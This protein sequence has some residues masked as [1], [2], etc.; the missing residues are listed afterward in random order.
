[1]AQLVAGAIGG[2][3][4]AHA[5]TATLA[6]ARGLAGR[7]GGRL[8][9]VQPA[10]AKGLLRVTFDGY[11]S[12][13]NGWDRVRNPEPPPSSHAFAEAPIDAEVRAFLAPIPLEHA[14]VHRA[15]H[16]EGDVLAAAC[17]DLDGDGGMELV[18][19]SRTRV[20]AGHVNAGRFVPSRTAPWSALAPRSPV[21]MREPLAGA[22]I[23][24]DATPRLLVG[25]T[26]RGGVA[27]DASLVLVG[28]LRGIPVPAPDDACAT[29][30]PEA[31]AFEGDVTGCLP[32]PPAAVKGSSLP[33]RYDAVALA[34]LPRP[35]GSSRSAQ[36]A[37][38]P[39]GKLQVRWGE[40]ATTIDNVG[41]QVVVADLDQDGVP[42]LVTSAAD[43]EDAITVASWDGA[44]DPRVRLHLAAPGGVRA[45]CVCPPEEGSV[46]ALVAVV[47]SEVWIV[48]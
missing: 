37:R 7:G 39:A 32:T 4:R 38:E 41:A 43:G 1:V 17:G 8:V 29:P 15:K 16:D 45:L 27:L 22:S 30:F 2:A 25:T 6:Q 21:P 40:A 12:S 47:G 35:D 14:S 26:D 28:A 3:T 23:V 36:V 13:S 5:G 20:A 31:S 33:P 9:F 19:V 42:E 18:L 11:P 34:N 24:G 10:I 44:S 48:R 46:P